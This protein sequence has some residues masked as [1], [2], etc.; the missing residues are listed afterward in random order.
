MILLC[1]CVCVY[2]KAPLY[3]AHGINISDP[4]VKVYRAK[5]TLQRSSRR[6]SKESEDVKLWAQALRDLT[7]SVPRFE[8]E[9]RFAAPDAAFLSV[10]VFTLQLEQT[11]YVEPRRNTRVETVSAPVPRSGIHISITVSL[12]AGV[13]RSDYD[14]LPG[15]ENPT[16]HSL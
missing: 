6:P 3:P 15:D 12:L 13:L 10:T 2:A 14:Y 5:H 11:V 9:D 4:Q 7:E 1:W 8:V 16:G